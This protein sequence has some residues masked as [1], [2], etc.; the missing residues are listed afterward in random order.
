MPQEICDNG[1]DDDGDGL[2]DCEDP[3]CSGYGECEIIDPEDNGA[4]QGGLES[5]NRLSEAIN[6]RNFNRAKSDYRFNR[7]T[8]NRL[9]KSVN[10]AERNAANTFQLQDLIP[11]EVIQEEEVIDATPSD[12][13]LS[14]IHI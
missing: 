12:L 8:A 1:I 5:N 11:L 9:E 4:N 13:L 7:A 10:Y 2:I 14:L 3:S 6:A